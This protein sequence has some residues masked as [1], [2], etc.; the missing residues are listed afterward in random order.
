MGVSK[1][2]NVNVSLQVLPVV[3]ELSQLMVHLLK[4]VLYRDDDDRL[5][6]SLLRLQARVREQAAVL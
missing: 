3:P 4:S 6:A 2:A 1:T 5:W